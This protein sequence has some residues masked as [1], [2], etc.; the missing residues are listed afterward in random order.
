MKLECLKDRLK[1]A[2]VQAERVT[3]KNLTLP[4]LS[5]VLLEAKNN[6]LTIK[7]TNLEVGLEISIPSKIE[8]EGSVAVNATILSNF[9]LNNNEEKLKIEL[10][11]NNLQVATNSTK[12]I[13]KS[14]STDDFPIIPIVNKEE[15]E[16]TNI[17]LKNFIFGLKSVVF[18]AAISDIK[19]EISSVFVYTQNDNMFFVATDSFR[20]AEKKINIKSNNKFS[21][22]IIPLKNVLEIIRVLEVVDDIEID[23]FTDKHQL[24]IITPNIKLTSRV[25]D[26]IYP[27][28]QQIMPV[29]FKTQATIKK[30]EL[31]NSLKI[32]NIFSD[33][34]NQ[35]EL[36]IKPSNE[37]IIINSKNQDVGENTIIIKGKIFGDELN[38]IINAKYLMDCLS[39]IE[40]NI[41]ELKI[42]EKN[43][44]LMVNGSD[45]D[46]RYIVMPI[47]R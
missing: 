40:S 5:S 19:P 1:Q 32:S 2:V 3:G 36:I 34:F 24:S 39:I 46:F 8:E 7:A 13:I 4:V 25:I 45:L 44:P 11:N 15:G 23:I 43:R 33:R 28:Y 10:I 17:K 42:N 26:G 20:L 37:E 29:E 41:I 6:K 27:D 22:L 38:L 12:T 9:L 18:S 31:L 14:L 16:K 30:D 47:N 35:I 21:R